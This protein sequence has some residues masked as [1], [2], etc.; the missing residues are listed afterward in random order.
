MVQVR[1][2][3]WLPWLGLKQVGA[4]S[5]ANVLLGRNARPGRCVL[6]RI[7][8]SRPASAL[9]ICRLQAAERFILSR[10]IWAVGS[11]GDGLG[12][13]RHQDGQ[14]TLGVRPGDG[15]SPQRSKTAAC[16]HHR[17]RQG[18]TSGPFG[19]RACL[20][21]PVDQPGRIR[22]QTDPNQVML[23]YVTLLPSSTLIV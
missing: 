17:Q 15:C 1:P 12:P 11:L 19:Q 7:R 5:F 13:D 9:R 22:H 2:W 6:S 23:Q 18:R 4:G 21:R 20:D 14:G 16:D 10:A 8:T 3:R